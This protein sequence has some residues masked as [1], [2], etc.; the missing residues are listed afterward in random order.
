MPTV[1]ARLHSSFEEAANE[2]TRKLW[3]LN[4]SKAF[5]ISLFPNMNM[6]VVFLSPAGKITLVERDWNLMEKYWIKFPE[7]LQKTWHQGP[8]SLALYACYSCETSL[9]DTSLLISYL[10][11]VGLDNFVPPLWTFLRFYSLFPSG[12]LPEVKCSFSKCHGSVSVSS[13]ILSGE[14]LYT[15]TEN[16][17]QLSYA[18][19]VIW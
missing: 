9:G 19:L 7:K 13:S 15:W 6:Y 17:S 16:W 1:S 5:K 8:C 12:L 18:S 11:L 3:T 10:F 4:Y 14:L 2:F